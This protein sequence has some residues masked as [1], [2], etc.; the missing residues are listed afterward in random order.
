MYNLPINV[1][2]YKWYV[3]NCTALEQDLPNRTGVPNFWDMDWY[4]SVA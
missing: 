1:I 3:L 2:L 4:W